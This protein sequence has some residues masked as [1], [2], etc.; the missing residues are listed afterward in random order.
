MTVNSLAP[1]PRCQSVGVIIRDSSGDL[2]VDS[3]ALAELRRRKLTQEQ[4]RRK[5]RP[6]AR[7]LSARRVRGRRSD[8][9][10]AVCLQSAVSAVS[11]RGPSVG[12]GEDAQLLGRKHVRKRRQSVTLT[13]EERLRLPCVLIKYVQR[14]GGLRRRERPPTRLPQSASQSVD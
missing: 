12:R 6:H 4:H 14:R 3:A 13:S 8:S 1:E 10:L 11:Q 9:A 2:P 5:M 7:K